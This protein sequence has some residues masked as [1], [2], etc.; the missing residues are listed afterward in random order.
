MADYDLNRLGSREFEHLAQALVTKCLGPTVLIFGDGPDG[1]REAWTDDPVTLPG[2]ERWPG[3]TV[4][5]AKFR[6]RPGDVA[7]N[8]RWLRGELRRELQAWTPA[9]RRRRGRPPDNM[10]II[11]NVPLSA[12]PE[13]GVD[14]VNAVFTEFGKEMHLVNHLVWHYDHLCRLLDD[15]PGVR[16]AFGG[17]ITP[18]DVLAEIH[19]ILVGD[20]ADLGDALRNHAAK[21]LLAEQWVRLGQS[22]S[23]S[24]E[25][26]LLGQVVVDLRA[27]LVDEDPDAKNRHPWVL[28]HLLALGDEV[29]RPSISP[30]PAPHVV[31]VGGPGQGKTT[32]GQAICQAY[33]VAL[34]P[35]SHGFGGPVT[36]ARRILRDHLADIALPVPASRR[37]PLRIELSRYADV[38]A[39]DE[40]T[41][42]FRYIADYISARG[43]SDIGPDRLRSWL[44]SWPWLLVLDG[45]DEVVASR[46]RE[47]MVDR[48]A[49]FLVDAAEVDADLLVV[50]TTR[51]RGY[52]GEFTS[53][54]YKHLQLID[55]RPDEALSY[56]RRLADVRHGE[57]PDVHRNVLERIA[58]A[59]DE[60]LTAR[61]MRTPLQVT[62][63]SLLLE[64]RSRVPQ[65]RHGLFDSYYNTIYSRETAKA[66]SIGRLLEQHSATINA[67]HEQIGLELQI[68]AEIDGKAEPVMPQ[69]ALR[70]LALQ[71][72]IEHE[73]GQ[74][75]AEDLADKIAFAATDRLVLLVPKN[76]TDVGFEVRSLQEYMAAR[77][78]VN[79]DDPTVVVR[80]RAIAPSTHWRN[81]WLL[82]AGRVASHREHLVEPLIGVLSAIDA[83]DY[84]TMQLAPGAELAADLLDD[85]FAATSPRTARLLLA[86]AV[87]ALRRPLDS[88]T[89]TTVASL[90]R[91]SANHGSGATRVISDVVKQSLAAA[92][93]QRITA[94]VA[95]HMWKGK[96]GSLGVL[97]RQAV[98]TLTQAL[99]AD[100]AE[101]LS[102]H[103]IRYGRSQ[104][105]LN[106]ASHGTLA[107]YIPSAG[108]DAADHAVAADLRKALRSVPVEVITT[109]SGDPAI[110]VVRELRTPD[111]PTLDAALTRPT[112]AEMVA[113]VL[114]LSDHE[115]AVGSALS[116][117]ARQW[118]QRRPAGPALR[119]L[120]TNPT[121]T[122]Q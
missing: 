87:E 98:P 79:A 77:A 85:G 111:Q 62:I 21:E 81:T 74:A 17:L 7:D 83:D 33:R 80:L 106:V 39:G 59:A 63:M 88:A 12:V 72:L 103:F 19:R 32:L 68:A 27:E 30:R 84:L 57:D 73:Y 5:Q 121:A 65:D 100:H 75:E 53:E 86:R 96:V 20:A 108:L 94:A 38:L 15:A 31:L 28:R 10:V 97:G 13:H 25:K 44:G 54:Q 23:R 26:L 91:A 118:L 92:P 122:M 4:V 50:A 112:I 2:G 8:S 3:R 119:Q 102:L 24:N 49:D 115:W 60:D 47:A 35:D 82:A 71:R 66:I 67:L 34:L 36:T 109:E 16:R 70:Q 120:P 14:A 45:F 18:G 117:I 104:R 52:A 22:G 93:P 110:A 29:L 56:A 113:E 11:T 46:V 1:G 105:S 6:H 55:L 41:S 107:D 69:A 99:G 76:D 95:L 64:G 61:M 78:I 43:V 58:E 37:W 40:H 90:F 116:T 48:V 42:L 9:R 89:S 114:R 51:P 101:A